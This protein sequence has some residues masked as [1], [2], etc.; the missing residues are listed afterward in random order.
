MSFET[1][2]RS[3]HLNAPIGPYK[4]IRHVKFI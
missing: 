3:I 2:L 4:G 1:T